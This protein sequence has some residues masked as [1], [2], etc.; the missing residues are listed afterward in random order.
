MPDPISILKTGIPDIDRQHE[1]LLT[2]LGE[3]KEFVGGKYEFAAA[4]TAVQALFDYTERHFAYEEGLLTRCCYPHLDEHISEHNSL[5]EN[6]RRQWDRIELG[7][8]D[9]A[10]EVVETIERWIVEHINAEDIEYAKFVN[11]LR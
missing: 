1:Q 4:F 3:L 8:S 7:Y 6:V 11:L 10:R 2:C 9:I 5:I